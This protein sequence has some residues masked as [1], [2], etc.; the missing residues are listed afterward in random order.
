MSATQRYVADQ[1]EGGED[2]VLDTSLEPEPARVMCV[3]RTSEDADLIV[4][5]LNA[6]DVSPPR[7]LPWLRLGGWI[8]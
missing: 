1:G 7:V 8:G 5:A 6:L 2:M 4:R 3:C